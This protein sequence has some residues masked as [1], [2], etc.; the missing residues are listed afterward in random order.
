[1][2]TVQL[3]AQHDHYNANSSLNMGASTVLSGPAPEEGSSAWEDLGDVASGNA[4]AQPLGEAAVGNYSPEVPCF[5]AFLIAIQRGTTTG[6]LMD[7]SSM[8]QN[9]SRLSDR[10]KNEF[11]AEIVKALNMRRT[12]SH[13]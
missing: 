7:L 9:S 6:E 12:Q 4:A 10:E 2:L 3:V 8:I 1:M 5:S 13:L 11:A